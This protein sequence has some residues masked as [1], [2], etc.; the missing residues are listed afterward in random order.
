MGS[1]TPP[2]QTIRTTGATQNLRRFDAALRKGRL[3]TGLAATNYARTCPRLVVPTTKTVL[4]R[5]I[6]LANQFESR[7]H[8]QREQLKHVG[9]AA[10]RLR[11]R[12]SGRMQQ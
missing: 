10:E 2:F 7:I 5:R 4:L 6:G 1:L 9:P 8:G 11:G 3:D 12:R